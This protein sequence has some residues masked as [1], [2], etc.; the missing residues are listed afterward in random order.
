MPPGETDQVVGGWDRVWDGYTA[1]NYLGRRL[2][3]ERI[4]TIRRIVERIGLPRVCSILDV[5]CGA[6]FT[7]SI[8][9]GLGFINSRGVDAA[10]NSL[11]LCERLH[12]FKKET[13]VYLADACRL[14][15]DSGAFDLVF[16][17]GVLEHYSDKSQA[18]KIV[19]ELC[20]LSS[21]YLLLLQPYQSSPVGLL[22]ELWQRIGRG[23]W[24]KEYHYS[25][26][27]YIGIVAVKPFKLVASGTCNWGEEMWLLFERANPAP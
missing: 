10:D 8:F 23:S 6:G 5:G 12:G 9:R 7:L 16:S 17:Q 2:H 21:K 18:A 20:R 26:K 4:K 11:L 24:E 1:P 13:D 3:A 14:P 15:F 27:D 19:A 22:K 25:R